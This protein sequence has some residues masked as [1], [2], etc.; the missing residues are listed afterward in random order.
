MPRASVLACRQNFIDQ[1]AT[2]FYVVVGV[3]VGVRVCY[4]VLKTA[5]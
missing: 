1:L 3:D 2:F 5:A 4:F